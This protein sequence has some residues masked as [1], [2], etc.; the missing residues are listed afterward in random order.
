MTIPI[1]KFPP[2]Y[3]IDIDKIKSFSC[4]AYTKDCKEYGPKF[5][6]TGRRMILLFIHRRAINCFDLKI[7]NSMKVEMLDITK[8]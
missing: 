2:D 3:K 7:E 1:L 4:L 5:I 6:N 8:D